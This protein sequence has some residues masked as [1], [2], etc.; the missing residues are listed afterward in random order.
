MN[1]GV[2]NKLIKVFKIVMAAALLST[3]N[4]EYSSI[5]YFS[6]PIKYYIFNEPIL[7]W[8][9]I[10]S[11]VCVIISE[12]YKSRYFNNYVVSAIVLLNIVSWWEFYND[13][14]VIA[15]FDSNGQ[16]VAEATINKAVFIIPIILIVIFIT[17]LIQIIIKKQKEKK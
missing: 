3:L 8:F 9:I 10:V 4:I 16:V 15:L 2:T 12:F 13:R 14:K 7:K 6:I 11:S 17:L 1:N 5:K